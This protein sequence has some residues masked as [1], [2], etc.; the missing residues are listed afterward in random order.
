LLVLNYYR[1]ENFCKVL[2]RIGEIQ[3]LVPECVSMMCLTATATKQVHEEVT[4]ILGLRNPYV[5]SISPSKSNILYVVK[6]GKD[7]H[8]T[9]APLMEQL[10]HKHEEFPR[11]IIYCQKLSDCGRI[12][13]LFKNYLG[14]YFTFPPGTSDQ[15]Q[16]R[17]IDMF[18]SCTDLVIKKHIL[19]NFSRPSHLRIVIATV[20]FGMGIDCP[21]VHQIFHLGAPDSI[22]AYIQ[23][24][25][26]AGR[27]GVQSVAVLL[28]I[29]GE[30]RHHID[31]NMKAYITNA[32]TCRRCMLFSNFEGHIS[33]AESPCMC[34]DIC[35]QVC[36][37]GLCEIKC[38]FF[39][40]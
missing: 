29:K 30:T 38:H 24:T 5:V 23:E 36:T 16:N 32:T 14:K 13:L 34:C 28:L 9:F 6:S 18:H 35:S 25:G 15:P 19:H 20:A 22:E 4:T 17:L 8:E 21:D 7:L 26:R 2:L 11:T 1:G 31:N 10:I 39:V 3:S 27:D 12:Y 40:I 37:C 33:T